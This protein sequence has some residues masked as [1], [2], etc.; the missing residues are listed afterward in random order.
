MGL[1]PWGL[2]SL[3]SRP[4]PPPSGVQ[5]GLSCLVRV[6]SAHWFRSQMPQTRT[7]LSLPLLLMSFTRAPG[8]LRDLPKGSQ[9]LRIGGQLSLPA[10]GRPERPGQARVHADASP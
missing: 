6:Q 4:P 9:G 7:C 1:V 2:R 8:A 5:L 3:R 10:L